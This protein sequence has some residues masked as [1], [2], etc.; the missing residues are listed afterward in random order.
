MPD[1]R[2]KGLRKQVLLSERLF[3]CFIRKRSKLETVIRHQIIATVS[4]ADTTVWSRCILT[5]PA[6]VFLRNWFGTLF[7]RR[8]LHP[9]FIP[10]TYL[11]A[12]HN[13]PGSQA[14]KQK[15][16]R[17]KYGKIVAHENLEVIEYL[18]LGAVSSLS[19]V[20]LNRFFCRTLLYRSC[21]FE[22]FFDKFFSA[23]CAGYFQP[24]WAFRVL[25]TEF[26]CKKTTALSFSLNKYH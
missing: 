8:T 21:Q 2:V 7:F 6:A 11:K 24:N 14:A 26:K 22:F 12:L 3:P 1:R 9:T 4:D 25:N 16:D 13:L 15:D 5:L 10:A 17:N 18:K 19:E 20:F 23:G